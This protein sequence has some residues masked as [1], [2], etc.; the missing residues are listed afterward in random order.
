MI[1]FLFLIIST[2]MEEIFM[3]GNSS[4]DCLDDEVDVESSSLE[5]S[6]ISCSNAVVVLVR[7]YC[8]YCLVFSFAFWAISSYCLTFSFY[9]FKLLNS[10]L[11]FF[12][13]SR[14]CYFFNYKSFSFYWDN[15]R[16]SLRW[17]I[18]FVLMV[19]DWFKELASS[20]KWS[21]SS[22]VLASSS[23]TRLISFSLSLRVF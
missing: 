1:E 17:V 6:T 4:K 18:S 13:Y 16:L 11:A 9:L 15:C 8:H 22:W 12:N 3:S 20:F 21:S 23:F 14:S 2:C 5:T 10:K 19:I 7:Y